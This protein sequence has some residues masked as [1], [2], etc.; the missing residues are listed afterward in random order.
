MLSLDGRLRPFGDAADN[1]LQLFVHFEIILV[2]LA[3]LVLA[4]GGA[5]S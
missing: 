5:R 2:L 3:A 4:G 1:H